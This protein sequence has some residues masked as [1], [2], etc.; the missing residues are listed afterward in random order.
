MMTGWLGLGSIYVSYAIG[1]AI[2]VGLYY[3]Q[4]AKIAR[5]GG[6]WTLKGIMP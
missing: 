1:I 4:K 2:Y 5:D 3:L 6:R